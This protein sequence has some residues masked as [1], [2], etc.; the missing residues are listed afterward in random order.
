MIHSKL[1]AS[2]RGPSRLRWMPS[3]SETSASEDLEVG[4]G[5]GSAGV[6]FTSKKAA[7]Q[8]DGNFE[9]RRSSG[10]SRRKLRAVFI[11]LFVDLR[12]K[13]SSE[14]LRQIEFFNAVC[15]N[16]LHL[17]EFA[18]SRLER[19]YEDSRTTQNT[20]HRIVY[21][22]LLYCL[23]LPPWLL[24]WFT[25][26]DFWRVHPELYPVALLHL[27]LGGV[28]LTVTILCALYVCF[29]RRYV[30]LRDA[31]QGSLKS[32]EGTSFGLPAAGDLHSSM[33]A[34][35]SSAQQEEAPSTSL[36]SYAYNKG[37][38]KILEVQP[39]T[40][41]K[42]LQERLKL[43]GFRSTTLERLKTIARTT[44]LKPKKARPWWVP[45]EAF[46]RFCCGETP[47]ILLFII[48]SASTCASHLASL[49]FIENGYIHTRDVLRLLRLIVALYALA[50]NW[51]ILCAFLTS[52][53]LF[54][55]P[56]K[57]FFLWLFQLGLLCLPPAAGRKMFGLTYW[58]EYRKLLSSHLL[59]SLQNAGFDSRAVNYHLGVLHQ[60][61]SR[62]LVQNVLL[63]NMATNKQ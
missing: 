50:A 18:D 25:L 51:F 16:P 43:G 38:T 8:A 37:L 45:P 21:I 62:S 40:E 56:R 36:T 10:D 3:F 39:D 49:W 26:R 35:A 47:L 20:H 13:A 57:C 17:F 53:S 59:F 61:Q 60:N 15:F 48:L 58:E 5:R 42:G 23:L 1:S 28:V 12:R 32:S 11:K 7:T 41:E 44:P 63:Y 46:V 54:I 31:S 4:G 34:A 29:V 33:G 2:E 6:S 24:M 30:A 27:Y 14:N 55:S 52:K 9:K 22:S 19:K